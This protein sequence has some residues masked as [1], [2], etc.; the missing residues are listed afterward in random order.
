M[1][2]SDFPLDAASLDEGT[3]ELLGQA[4]TALFG[5]VPSEAA[6]RV[7]RDIEIVSPDEPLQAAASRMWW[8]KM[9]ALPVLEDGRFA[10]ALSED[11][12]LHTLADRLRERPGAAGDLVLWESVLAGTTVR[13][14]MSPREDT[15]VVRAGTPLVTGI[16]ATFGP[17]RSRR[18]KGYLFVL[19]ERD[20]PMRVVSFRDIARFVV[21]LYD[22]ELAPDAFASPAHFEH[23]QRIAWRVLDL[24]LGTLR[25]EESLGSPPDP[26]PADASAADT[27][28]RLAS[29]ARGY[30]IVV[31]PAGRSAAPGGALRGICTRRDLLRALKSP[32][33][34]L[35]ALR[36]ARLMSEPVKTVSEVDTFCGLFKMMAIEGFRHMPLVD[37]ADRVECVISLWQGVGLL[38]HRQT[39][40]PR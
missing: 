10:G 25:R 15:A 17:T 2:I 6:G 26:L 33:V 24:S 7:D 35:D 18:R 36:A 23:A 1:S 30:A 12:L 38:A 9:G 5:A 20:V 21:R 31:A 27:M 32:F 19:D 28:E 13:D 14:A 39:P 34:T 11:D 8:R 37:D 16:E 3:H 4:P 22:G 29:R 40:A